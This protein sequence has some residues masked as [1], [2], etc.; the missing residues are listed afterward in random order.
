METAATGD[1]KTQ[2]ENAFDVEKGQWTREQEER[3]A[4][5]FEDYLRTGRAQNNELKNLYQKL[6]EYISRVY[7]ALK[8][9]I[10]F[11]KDID[12]VYAQLMQGDDSILAAAER[13][14]AETERQEA[15]QK[16]A[17]DATPAQNTNVTQNNAED[18]IASTRPESS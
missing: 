14:V 18:D 16:R 3:F 15:D 8:A 13:A 10:D 6:A 11:T 9:R 7:H 17:Q 1:L 2:A 4:V 5:G 12:D